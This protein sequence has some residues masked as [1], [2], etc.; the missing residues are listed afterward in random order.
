MKNI[1]TDKLGYIKYNTYLYTMET[2]Q[3]E[4][5]IKLLNDTI[6]H[7]NST[8]RSTKSDG[9]CTYVAHYPETQ[10]CAIGRLIADKELCKKL[11]AISGDDG[12]GS[13]KNPRVF[14]MLPKELQDLGQ[15]FLLEIQCLHDNGNYWDENGIAE[16][17]LN[18]VNRIKLKFEL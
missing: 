6:S 1:I 14:N 11:D 4:T 7:F 8:N 16:S 18:E 12:G 2:S 17:G 15:D 5:R 3:K 9:D 10:G 13:V